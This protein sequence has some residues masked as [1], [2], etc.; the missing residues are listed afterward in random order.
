MGHSEG[1]WSDK[2][3]KS[4]FPPSSSTDPPQGDLESPN[5]R[6]TFMFGLCSK[7]NPGY[8]SVRD[9]PPQSPQLNITEA[10]LN[11]AIMFA[12]FNVNAFSHCLLSAVHC[13]SHQQLGVPPL[14]VSKP[15]LPPTLSITPSENVSIF[16]LLVQTTHHS[17]A[18]HLHANPAFHACCD[19]CVTN[20]PRTSS[21]CKRAQ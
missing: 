20:Q 8:K 2:T 10:V 14:H 21:V 12:Y 19:P 18:Q 13:K 16:S 4:F 3:N 7:T 11:K 5:D 9:W 6:S 1:R 15:S 17:G